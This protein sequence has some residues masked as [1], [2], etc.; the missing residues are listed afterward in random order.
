ML[1]HVFQKV[2][3]PYCFYCAL[4]Q[5]RQKRD[6]ILKDIINRIFYMDDFLKSIS[7]EENLKDL[8]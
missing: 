3:S 4:R 6:I 8:A 7:T 1:V 2:D 5:V